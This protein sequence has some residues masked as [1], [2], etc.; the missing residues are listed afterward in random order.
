MTEYDY[1]PEAYE[2]YMATQTRI[3]NWIDNQHPYQPQYQR[4]SRPPYPPQQYPQQQQQPYPNNTPTRT[5]IPRHTRAPTRSPSLPVHA[6]TPRPAA[7]VT[8]P[9]PAPHAL[10]H[11]LVRDEPAP[12][13]RSHTRAQPVPYPQLAPRRSRTL[14]P[15]S[16]NVVYH[17]YEAPRGGPTYVILR[18]SPCMVQTKRPQPLLKRLFT[19]FG[20][21]GSSSGASP[22]G[23]F[24]PARR[25]PR[26]SSF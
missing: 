14:P 26:R 2:R 21:W 13:T 23:K 15:Q 22:K 24:P 3:S 11:I 7:H 6:H 17:T 20:P 18:Q 25:Y 16:Q 10:A 9:P 8:R 5:P 1:S 19:S 12:T 4:H